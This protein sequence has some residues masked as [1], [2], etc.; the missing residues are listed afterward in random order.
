MTANSLAAGPLL[1]NYDLIAGMAH[2]AF[3]DVVKA[4]PGWG[5]AA[6]AA[7]LPAM[8]DSLR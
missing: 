6:A 3:F 1:R 7:E 2:R 8:S 4:E 5:A